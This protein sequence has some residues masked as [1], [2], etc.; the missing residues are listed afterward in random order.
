ML[1]LELIKNSTMTLIGGVDPLLETMI[2]FTVID[3]IT[4]STVAKI[5][6]KMTSENTDNQDDIS[7][8]ILTQKVFQK[9]GMVIIIILAHQIDSILGTNAIREVSIIFFM[10]IEAISITKHIHRMGVPIPKQ[11][12]EILEQMK[13]KNE[14]K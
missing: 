9:I 4:G 11:L 7:P 1:I 10:I 8:K 5:F 13:Q 3:I 6:K 12:E 14:K 2:L